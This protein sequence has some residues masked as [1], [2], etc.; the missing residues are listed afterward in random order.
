MSLY[1]LAARY[2]TSIRAKA[3]QYCVETVMTQLAIQYPNDKEYGVNFVAG[4]VGQL[5]FEQ[6]GGANDPDVLG[7]EFIDATISYVALNGLKLTHGMIQLP[8]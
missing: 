4:K 8:E 7:Q 6:F 1:R 2:E 5:W 3:L